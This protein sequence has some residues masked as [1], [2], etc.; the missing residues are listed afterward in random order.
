MGC[1]NKILVSFGSKY[2]EAWEH[3]QK[4]PNK[5]KY[6]S[7]LVE[8]DRHN[9]SVIDLASEN[10]VEKIKNAVRSVLEEYQFGVVATKKEKADY[11]DLV[12]DLFNI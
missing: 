12:D 3:L 4:Q 2:N 1:K 11:S 10:D 5:S 6:I 9:S 7:E 8:R